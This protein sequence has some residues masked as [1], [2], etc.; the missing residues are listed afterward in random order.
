MSDDLYENLPQDSERAFLLLEK[1]FRDECE[2]QVNRAHQEENVIVFYVDYIAQVFAA[3]TELGLSA[4]F[5]DR[6]PKIEDVTYN[7]YINFSK[8]VKH[9]R[10][11]LEIRHGRRVQGYSV[12]FDSATK[13]KMRHHLNQL[14]GIFDKL[15]V[16]VQKRE[17]LFAK[18][19]ELQQEVDRDRTR[20]DSYAALTIEAAGVVGEV[21]EKS[22]VLE[23]LDGI[24]RVFW[25]A[26]KQEETKRL[27]VPTTPKRIEPP[28]TPKI[29]SKKKGELDDDIPF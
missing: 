4:E 12:R 28:R 20:F 11:M 6:V 2:E 8:D 3:I 10:T 25:G 17:A 18:L 19:D 9:Y 1:R 26:K 24:A 15:Q 16:E 5:N 27:P 13:E 23:I 21:V 22:R 7:T 14:R 29:E